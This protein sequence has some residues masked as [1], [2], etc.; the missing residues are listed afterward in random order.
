[1]PYDALPELERWALHRTHALAARVRA[2]YEAYEFHVI[3]HA[4][5]NF[6]AVD[7]SALY[8]DVRKDRL[9]CERPDEPERRATQTVLHAMLDALVRLDGA[10]PVLHRRRGLELPAGARRSRACSWPASPSRPATWRDDA[11]AAR[12]ERL[13]AVR[14]RGHEGAR[15]GAAG[16]RR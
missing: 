6:C 15:G 16:R 4:L 14:A 13:L 1:M 2:A 11:L 9:Y 5:N 7:L 10:G 12:F 8:L 3:Y